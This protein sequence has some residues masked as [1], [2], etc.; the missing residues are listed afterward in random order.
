MIP[1]L[2]INSRNTEVD[3]TTT[4]IIKGYNATTLNT[5]ANM[6]LIISPLKEKA[7]LLSAGIGRL[8]EKSTQKLN[9]ELRDEKVDGL[10]YL[11]ISSIHSPKTKIKEA[12][13]YLLEIFDQYGLKMKD[14]SYTR[15]SSLIHSLLND[16]KT[17]EA[18]AAVA[19]IPAC[20]EYIEALQTAQDNFESN[21]LAFEAAQAQEGTVEN[22]SKLKKVVTEIINDLLVPYLNVM[23]QLNNALYGTYAGTVAEI[24]AANNEVV[25]KRRKKDRPEEGD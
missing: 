11:L 7:V 10:Y 15:E 12:A 9:D 21:R 18:L 3:G 22:A 24:I 17:D 25:K 2:M 1:L 13:A 4:Q 8:K 20:N 5:D 16:Y 23:A 14:E 19:D 6:E